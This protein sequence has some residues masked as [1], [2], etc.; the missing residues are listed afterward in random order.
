M[1]LYEQKLDTSDL[2][3]MDESVK[4]SNEFKVTNIISREI[5]WRQKFYVDIYK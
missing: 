4:T 1:K 2:R 3:R 5:V